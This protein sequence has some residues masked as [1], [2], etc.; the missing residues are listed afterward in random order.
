MYTEL[1]EHALRQMNPLRIYRRE[2]GWSLEKIAKKAGTTKGSL[3]KIET[4]AAGKPTLRTFLH[5]VRAMGLAVGPAA[6]EYMEWF[7]ALERVREPNNAKEDVVI[8][9]LDHERNA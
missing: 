4:G 8:G 1:S 6:A 2:Q 5:V 9:L 7:D 3:S